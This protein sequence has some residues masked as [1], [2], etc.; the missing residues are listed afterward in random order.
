MEVWKHQQVSVCLLHFDMVYKFRSHR[1]R[2]N[3]RRVNA[4]P[5]CAVKLGRHLV[6]MLEMAVFGRV[7]QLV[8]HFYS[9]VAGFKTTHRPTDRWICRVR[10]RGTQH[11]MRWWHFMVRFLVSTL[12]YFYSAGAYLAS[13]R[14]LIICSN[15]AQNWILN[16]GRTRHFSFM[17]SSS[18][19]IDLA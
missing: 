11:R 6:I 2:R 10:V 16:R 12:L 15:P 18:S 13:N 17:N 14:S 9:P 3:K 1:R 4:M 8:N 7:P 19:S 5:P